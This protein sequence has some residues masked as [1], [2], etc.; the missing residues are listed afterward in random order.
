VQAVGEKILQSS[1]QHLAAA[2][3]MPNPPQ[4]GAIPVVVFNAL[5]WQRSGMVKL[6]LL[7]QPNSDWQV[8][9][10]TEQ[11]LPAEFD[12][13]TV[14][15][16]ATDIPANG[17]ALFWLVSQNRPP[18][19]VLPPTTFVLENQHLQATINPVTGA[20][21]QLRDKH[22]DRE[23]LNGDGNQLQFFKDQGQYWDAW[24]I[25]PDYVSHPLPGAELQ[26]IR[27]LSAAP[28]EQRLEVVSRFQSSRFCQIY[29]LAA[30]SPYLKVET[31]VNWQEQHVL[32]KAAFP[33]QITANAATYET[34]CA[35]IE[36]PTLPN[37]EPLDLRQAAKWEVPALRWADLT[38]V[39]ADGQTW[40]LSVLNDCKYGYDASPNC[41]RLTLLR[42]SVWPDPEADT[43]EHHFCYALYP[44]ADS[45]QA[46]QTVRL[47]YEFNHA[48]QP[49]LAGSPA[50]NA[51]LPPRGSFFT[52]D[53]QG[54]DHS[55][56]DSLVLM[57]FKQ[58]ERAMGAVN[59]SQ[60][61]T[62]S[63]W[64]VRCYESQGQPSQ[65]HWQSQLLD[66]VPQAAVDILETP[67]ANDAG[68]PDSLNPLPVSPWR[69]VSLRLQPKL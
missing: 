68:Q 47:G 7:T 17:Y 14:Q 58:A 42:G 51:N 10:T 11:L 45:W 2:I 55:A 32:V 12:Q 26:S 25:D 40:G 18:E 3:V 20:L 64:I 21:G 69:V 52:L 67:L 33:L 37:P 39:D 43:G 53:H 46:A 36:R 65:L 50:P 13:S 49:V 16:W 60:N 29:T 62:P 34:L 35:A 44:H 15:F 66:L 6:Y 9:T 30:D 59:F 54:A 48:L 31:W 38:G 24:N 28:L 1:L 56:D 8:Y 19:F 5:N 57:A 4:P 63:D 27:W 61:P 22:Q 41:L 23:L